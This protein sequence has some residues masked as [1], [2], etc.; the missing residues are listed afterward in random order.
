M[1][2]KEFETLYSTFLEF[3]KEYLLVSRIL[4]MLYYDLQTQLPEKGTKYR[5][6]QMNYL[7]SKLQSLVKDNHIF[8]VIESLLSFETLKELE[9][10]NLE[11]WRKKILR[12][13]ILPS[14]FYNEFELL[15]L[16][17]ISIWKKGRENNSSKEY[18][19]NLKKILDFKQKEF[20][21]LKEHY[22]NKTLYEYYLDQFEPEITIKEL[23]ACFSTLKPK[24]IDLYQKIIS[25]N[26]SL[27]SFKENKELQL[28]KESQ[29]KI[30]DFLI[31]K[32]IKDTSVF[33]YG[34][35]V[36]PFMIPL[37]DNDFRITTAFREDPLFSISSTIHE[38]GHTLYEIGI[39]K[40]FQHS[41]LQEVPSMG[42]HESQS[43]FWESYICS[44]KDFLKS[45]F[46][47]F[48]KYYTQEFPNTTL[49]F[50]EFYVIYN[51]VKGNLIRI[52][53]DEVTYGLHIIIRY[54]IEKGLFD[55]TYTIEDI[56]EIWNKKYV[57]CFGKKPKSL[58]EGFMQD[59][60]WSDGSFGY[61]PTYLLGRIFASHMFKKI[62]EDLGKEVFEK[63]ISSMDFTHIKHWLEHNI[64][65]FGNSKSS[66][67]IMKK[68]IK[69]PLSVEH[70]YSYLYEKYSDIYS[71]QK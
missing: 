3:E 48:K 56:E 70:Y 34:E 32:L 24:L 25:S 9:K 53:G 14:D 59:S 39:S 17:T 66:L 45:F 42:L 5:E 58:K 21:L 35:T 69:N 38:C 33:N 55:G 44:S 60:H 10:R 37:G 51:S 29:K 23:D 27:E 40:Y 16:Q 41:Q 71:L 47:I 19:S 13:S 30:I 12:E 64:W 61:F 7:Q 18:I 31:S 68:I 2:K 20:E 57:E 62:Q 50:D 46:P 1:E 36:H 28:S 43:L 6:E 8:E 63:D 15:K 22:P 65:K 67:E 11:L 49:T 54:E 4:W 26:N 52:E